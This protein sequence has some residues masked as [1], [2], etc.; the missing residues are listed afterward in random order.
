MAW[1]CPC[2]ENHP[3]YQEVLPVEPWLDLVLVS[4][5]FFLFGSHT[6]DSGKIE[7]GIWLDDRNFRGSGHTGDWRVGLD[8]QMKSYSYASTLVETM[9]SGELVEKTS[10]H[11]RDVNSCLSEKTAWTWASFYPKWLLQNIILYPNPREAHISS[12]ARNPN[13]RE[14]H[15]SP[16]VTVDQ[17]FSNNPDKIKHDVLE[18]GQSELDDTK[19]CNLDD[20]NQRKEKKKS[21]NVSILVVRPSMSVC[22]YHLYISVCITVS[23]S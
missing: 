6:G 11:C 13:P 5:S 19:D 21:A 2:F 17:I 20:G 9:T 22:M 12:A 18:D 4:P 16:E 14:T 15:N 23:F 1:S 10:N 8:V 3:F 7:G